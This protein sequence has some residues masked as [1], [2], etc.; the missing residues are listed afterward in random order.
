[1]IEQFLVGSDPNERV[2]NKALFSKFANET[3]SKQS[4]RSNEDRG[5]SLAFVN[6]SMSSVAGVAQLNAIEGEY[7]ILNLYRDSIPLDF[8]EMRDLPMGNIPV[9]RTRTINPINVF[10][11]SLSGG[12]AIEYYATTDTGVQV[13]IPGPITTSKVMIPNLSNIYDMVKLDQR[14]AALDRLSRDLRNRITDACFNVAMGQG[15]LADPA[16]SIQTYFS[17]ANQTWSAGLTYTMSGSYFNN[18]NVY[19]LDPGVVQGGVPTTNCFDLSAEGGL[20]K[21]VFM[22]LNS[23]R[24]QMGRNLSTIY[25]PNSGAPWE[26]FQQQASIVAAQT[27]ASGNNNPAKAITP[28][29]WERFQSDDFGG[30][31]TVPFFG[32]NVRIKRQNWLPKGY[33]FVTTDRPA[34]IMWDRLDLMSN[35][36]A[37]YGSLETPV[38]AFYNYRSEGRQIVLAQPSP[39]LTN[40]LVIKVQ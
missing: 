34:V 36:G 15:M 35:N 40:F 33:C 25:V 6:K 12:S 21:N 23:W 24:M 32:M 30:E 10:V 37:S 5:K 19:Y 28:E 1:M 38:D 2:L 20:T 29:Q 18:K 7:I 4:A 13:S 31:V 26:A 11:G 3:L 22:A 39:L 9:Y 8:V 17:A 27:G 16:A 14:Q